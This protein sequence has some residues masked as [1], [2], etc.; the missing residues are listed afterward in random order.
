MSSTIK[1]VAAKN[2]NKTQ[3]KKVLLVENRYK[4]APAIWR[5]LSEKQRIVYNNIRSM[6]SDLILPPK[7]KISLKEFNVISHNFAC[8]SAWGAYE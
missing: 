1:K 7:L 2:R 8:M 6:R 5:K 3:P 4:C